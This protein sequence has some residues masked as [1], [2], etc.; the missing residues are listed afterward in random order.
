MYSC[1]SALNG[2]YQE[3][4]LGDIDINNVNTFIE[5]KIIN[6]TTRNNK[7]YANHIARLGNYFNIIDGVHNNTYHIVAVNWLENTGTQDT[8]WATNDN[9]LILPTSMLSH[10]STSSETPRYLPMN[11]TSTTGVS[12]NPLN[13]L[14]EITQ[15][16]ETPGYQ[17][18]YGSDM[19]QIYLP[20]IANNLRSVL[21]NHMR[22]YKSALTQSI[23]LTSAKNRGNSDTFGSVSTQYVESSNI[24]AWSWQSVYL[25]LL[26]EYEVIGAP[27]YSAVGTDFTSYQ[28]LPIYNFIGP[29]H[30]YISTSTPY[31]SR[32][33]FWFNTI[34]SNKA[35]SY[36]TA[37]NAISTKGAGEVAIGVK[38][39]IM[40]A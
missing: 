22:Q 36:Y 31:A 12:Q 21:G 8:T 18:Y 25:R 17:G 39:L 7:T 13:P 35:F 33:G 34:S 40:L 19:N 15:G 32:Y 37:N 38:P 5:E 3:K 14:Y 28:K 29:M 6:Y 23:D 1:G 27:I 30:H 26:S 2:I 16:V 4:F 9:Y 24:S 20:I 10:V 11:S